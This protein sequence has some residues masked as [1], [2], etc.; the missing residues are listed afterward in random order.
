M[1]IL[2]GCCDLQPSKLRH[3]IWA[4][5]VECAQPPC[6]RSGITR[7]VATQLDPRAMRIGAAQPLGGPLAIGNRRDC[8]QGAGAGLLP[9][10][11]GGWRGPPPS[12][13]SSAE[14]GRQSLAAAV[15]RAHIR[16]RGG[17]AGLD[18]GDGHGGP[19]VHG[20]CNSMSIALADRA[21]SSIEYSLLNVISHGALA[22]LFWLKMLPLGGASHRRR[23]LLAY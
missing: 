4:I 8:N 17:T 16:G 22:P 20:L 9:Y 7:P 6:G 5:V 2:P 19:V 21:C 14:P 1:L 18:D 12:G 10:M 3:Q 11:R 13:L 15:R 23:D